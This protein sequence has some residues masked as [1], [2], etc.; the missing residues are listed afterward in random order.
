MRLIKP[1]YELIACSHGVEDLI[2][3]G[4]RVC[5]NSKKITDTDYNKQ[6][7]KQKDFIQGL[8]KRGHESPLE[9]AHFTIKF[10]ISRAIANELTRHRIAS[11]CQSSTR[12]IKYDDVEFIEPSWY[13]DSSIEEQGK[14]MYYLSE[15]ESFYKA[16]IQNGHPPQEARDVLPLATATELIMTANAREMR[17]ILKLRVDKAAHPDMRHIMKVVLLDFRWQ[18]PA[19]FGDLAC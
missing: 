5:Y 18:F 9:H 2:E 3:T 10:K 4:A 12:Y 15:C 17:H 8:I 6:Q 1:S 7:E 16:M 13:L 14:F 19:I 11:F